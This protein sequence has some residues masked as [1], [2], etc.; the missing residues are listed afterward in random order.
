MR[1]TS[2]KIP[3]FSLVE[4]AIALVIMGIILGGVLKGKDLLESARLKTVISQV[5]QYKL[6]THTFYDQYGALLGDFDQAKAYINADLED[7]N[8]NG[9][10]EGLGLGGRNSHE[11]LSFWRH[12][13]A[14]EMITLPHNSSA[15]VPSLKIGGIITISHH[16]EETLIGH[17]FILGTAQGQK[18]T[19]ALLTPLQAL[20][21]ARKI[22]SEDPFSGTVQ[23]RNGTNASGCLKGS[24]LNAK[25]KNVVCT[26]YVRL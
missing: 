3:A 22:D 23:V 26:L 18:G 5:N 10:V 20:N 6:A 4:L 8:N 17:W 21:L 14:A 25:N 11:A 15:I 2:I 12:L 7:G 24:S 9:E 19:G 16:P 1:L 13:Q